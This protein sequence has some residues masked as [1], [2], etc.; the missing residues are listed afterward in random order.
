LT[1]IEIAARNAKQVV[2]ALLSVELV[3]EYHMRFPPRGRPRQRLSCRE[4]S[5]QGG[6]RVAPRINSLAAARKPGL[7]SSPASKKEVVE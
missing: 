2:A 1:V 4:G 6:E 5:V 7:A 3:E